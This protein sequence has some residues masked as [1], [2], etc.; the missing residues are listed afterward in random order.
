MSFQV[1]KSINSNS[2]IYY[3]TLSWAIL[4]STAYLPVDGLLLGLGGPSSSGRLPQ[5]P[6]ELPPGDDIPDHA[7]HVQ[8]VHIIMRHL[9]HHRAILAEFLK[10]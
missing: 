2:I 4:E 7:G 9:E 8:D 6:P 1:Y 10:Y 3:V 5:D